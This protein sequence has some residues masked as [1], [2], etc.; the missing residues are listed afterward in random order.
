MKDVIDQLNELLTDVKIS[1]KYLKKAEKVRSKAESSLR[2]AQ[3]QIDSLK[4]NLASNE[5][6][7]SA[8]A[9]AINSAQDI[10]VEE[11]QIA[12]SKNS[13]FAHPSFMT[14]LLDLADNPD[15]YN[16]QVSGTGWNRKAVVKLAM[17]ALAGSIADYASAISDAR[18]YMN[19]GK[20][21]PTKASE[22]WKSYYKNRPGIV[23]RTIN[24]RMQF[25][26]S[27]APF[28]SLLNYGNKVN[29]NS[30]RGGTPYPN[31]SGTRFVEK[32]QDRIE[33][34]FTMA[35]LALK[36][37][38]NLKI[39]RLQSY[40]SRVSELLGR[41]N[42]IVETGMGDIDRSEKYHNGLEMI[43]GQVDKQVKGLIESIKTSKIAEKAKTLLK[44]A[45]KRFSR[46]F[47]YD[48]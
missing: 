27:P 13:E 48:E 23:S 2:D 33:D 3:V 46:L 9:V 34:E 30:D 11:V 43:T 38:N 21:D 10:F 5:G 39:K 24:I 12:V 29:M 44:A 16:I 31:R 41:L 6:S 15:L 47:G 19:V 28:W 22:L 45:G 35:L 14:P 4:S 8:Q 42:Q 36:Q 26:D 7:A 18:E 1:K 32:I 37:D 40:I 25:A 20:S 17:D